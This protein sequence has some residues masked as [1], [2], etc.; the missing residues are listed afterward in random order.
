M[1]LDDDEAIELSRLLNLRSTPEEPSNVTEPDADD[2]VH[3]RPVS[4]DTYAA[5]DL[6]YR[7]DSTTK[8]NTHQSSDNALEVEMP[9]VG[10]KH[11]PSHTPWA[12]RR[13][14]LLRLLIVLAIL[15]IM[16]E[17]MY[18]LSGKN[19][20]LAHRT[21]TIYGHTVPL[22]VRCYASSHERDL[23][24]TLLQCFQYLESSGAALIT[25]PEF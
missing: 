1:A 20:G 5:S 3:V 7:Q 10:R 2:D 22:P 11:V 13:I 4:T 18:Y 24:L 9:P 8:G 14:S 23:D 19:Q 6:G 15:I 12:L 17:I 16:L 21:S 25:I